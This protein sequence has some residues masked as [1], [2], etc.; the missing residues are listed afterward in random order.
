M[1]CW[2]RHTT[3]A[4]PAFGVL[5]HL[6]TASSSEPPRRVDAPAHSRSSCGRTRCTAAPDTGIRPAGARR[7]DRSYRRCDGGCR[8]LSAIRCTR[9]RR[10]RRH[11]HHAR[12]SRCAKDGRSCS[13]HFGVYS[14]GRCAPSTDKQIA[15]LENFAAQAVIAM[16]NA[17]LITETREALEQQTATAEVLAGHQFFAR[18]SC[19]GVRGDA[20]KGNA[21]VR[22]ARLASAN[23]YD[24]EHFRTAALHGVP[25][26]LAELLRQAAPAPARIAR[27]AHRQWR[28]GRP[29]PRSCACDL[30]RAIRPASA[31][32]DAGT[33]G[34][35]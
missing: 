18:R 16:E 23:T 8:I 35:C 31:L 12:S 33:R 6:L 27:C 13:V 25:E 22:S 7:A 17:R 19:A 30:H 14:P 11:S 3:C 2:R 10:S 28:G 32:C 1:R 34:P 5:W 26:P 15:L 9:G 24:G 21:A 4:T 29:H 20:R